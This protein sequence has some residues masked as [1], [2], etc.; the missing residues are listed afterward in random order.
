MKRGLAELAAFV[1][2]YMA[3]RYLNDA[4]AWGAC[5]GGWVLAMWVSLGMK[6]GA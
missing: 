4:P 2:G 3:L 1:I 5:I 6:R